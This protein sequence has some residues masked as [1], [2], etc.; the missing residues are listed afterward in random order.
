M[1]GPYY[2]FQITSLLSITSRFTGI[3]LSVVTAPLA[4]AW[5]LALAAGTQSFVYVQ[6]FLGTWAGQL[7][8][9]FSLFSLWFHLLNGIRHLVW[10]TGR[11]FEK[12][13]IWA[14]GYLVIAATLVL[15]AASFWVAL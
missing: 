5:L 6:A 7:L 3:W 13:Q 1:L 4:I 15:T 9:L 2:R 8:A 10:D 14:S 11:G 12:S